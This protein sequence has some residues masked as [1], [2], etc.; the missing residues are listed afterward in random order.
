AGMQ[1]DNRGVIGAKFV[2]LGDSY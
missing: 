2:I 1:I